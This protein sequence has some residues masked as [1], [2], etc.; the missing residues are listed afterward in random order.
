MDGLVSRVVGCRGGGG[1]GA[2]WGGGGGGGGVGGGGSLKYSFLLNEH[3]C[4]FVC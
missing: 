1:G 4:L 3:F 2:E